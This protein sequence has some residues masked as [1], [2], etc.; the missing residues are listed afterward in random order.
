MSE[1]REAG[2]TP[3]ERRGVRA[4]LLALSDRSGSEILAQSL[5]EAGAAVYATTGTAAHLRRLGLEVRPV[6]ELTRSA[7]FLGGRVK[8]L[9]ADLFGAILA[10][11]DDPNHRREL[12][13]RGLPEVDLVA[14]TLYPFEALPRNATWDSAVER[15]D[16]G[17][18][19]LL[20]AAA[21]NFE[22]VA[23]LTSPAQ[24]EPLRQSLQRGGTTRPERRHLAEA[25]FART[26]EYDALIHRFFW[27]RGGGAAPELWLEPFR[28]SR[29]L[30]YGEN[31]H[32]EAY[33]FQPSHGDPWW[34]RGALHEG[35]ELS[36]NNLLDL[37]SAIRLC[38]EFVPPA[39]GIVKH[40][41][42]SSV[43][44]GETALEAFERALAG[45]PVSAYGGVV[46]VN[47][48]LDAET[49]EAVTRHFFECL[50]A[51]RLSEA[52]RRLLVERKRLRVVQ[53]GVADLADPSAGGWEARPLAGGL[54]VQRV[55]RGVG[56]IELRVV[57]HRAPTPGEMEAL[58]F[59]WTVV[60]RAR[61]NAVAIS[62]A[63]QSLGIG[64][65][66][67]SRIDALHVALLKAG[68]SQHD[69]RDAV[70]ASD[71]FFPFDDWVAVAHEAGITACI[72]P[73]GSVRDAESIAA[74][75]T[76]GL[77]MVFTGRRQFRH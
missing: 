60:G 14:V 34:T 70:L 28:R 66:Q 15:I 53:A 69:T 37:E 62:T 72:Q 18:V 30:R 16:V 5:L 23:V 48:E 3:G 46:A 24:Y 17:G 74:C 7:E 58:H 38:G 9:S 4:A 26:A 56:E 64:S 68:R 22:S 71:G 12:A 45:D 52:A 19:S 61:S 35:R 39:C 2:P 50:G 11:R 42:P 31:P 73:G 44:L 49:A 10:R 51:P 20:R 8:T 43:G 59:A 57:T 21:K 1:E 6:E 33:L 77:A 32:Q 41:E 65:G 27:E 54:L 76:V 29:S 40:N 47:R 25:A 67:T 55:P 75:N 13:E 36:F 63:G